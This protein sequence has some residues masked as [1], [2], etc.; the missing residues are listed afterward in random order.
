VK[1]HAIVSRLALRVHLTYPQPVDNGERDRY[2]YEYELRLPTNVVT[3]TGRIIE[4]APVAEG[5]L[6]GVASGLTR[7]ER[8]VLGAAGTDGR[9]ILRALV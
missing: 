7:V 9:L 4:S 2:V 5:E 6:L 8:I 1:P 3:S